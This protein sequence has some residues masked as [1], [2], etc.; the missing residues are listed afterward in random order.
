MA[1]HLDPRYTQLA[2]PGQ[3][4]LQPLLAAHR[5]VG[6]VEC[7]HHLALI[8]EGDHLWL[9]LRCRLAGRILRQRAAHVVDRRAS[10][11]VR[12]TVTAIED[13]ILIFIPIL[14]VTD[15]A[16][17]DRT[18]CATACSPAGAFDS[19][20]ATARQATEQ[21]ADGPGPLIEGRTAVTVGGAACQQTGNHQ[22]RQRRL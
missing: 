13:T 3:Q 17:G 2:E 14:G 10:R 19:A 12:A 7:E 15:Q 6:R 18:Q 4:A 9:G 22:Q 8:V 5:Q 20:Q 16:A 1:N 11:R 21:A